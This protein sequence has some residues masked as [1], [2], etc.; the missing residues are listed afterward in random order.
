M[1]RLHVLLV[2]ARGLRKAD[3]MGKSDPYVELTFLS[4]QLQKST[5]KKQTLDPMWNETFE[6]RG[7][8]ASFVRAGL[9]L[10]LF[11]YDWGKAPDSIGEAPVPL[12]R[13]EQE[14]HWSEEVRIPAPNTGTVSFTFTWLPD[15]QA[16]ERTPRVSISSMIAD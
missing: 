15:A 8:R 12:R 1:G 6:F 10:K 11:D 9:E 4:Q 13:L 5:T 16:V 14:D 3:F 7:P 2:R